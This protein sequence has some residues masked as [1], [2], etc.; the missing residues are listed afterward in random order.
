LNTIQGVVRLDQ[1][2]QEEKS[3]NFFIFTNLIRGQTL[4]T[5]NETMLQNI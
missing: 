4:G 1:A 5:K 2:F 3:G